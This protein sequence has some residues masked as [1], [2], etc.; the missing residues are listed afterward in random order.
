MSD[1]T[2]APPRPIVG[3]DNTQAGDVHMGSVGGRDIITNTTTGADPIAM[4]DSMFA[5]I[6]EYIWNRDQSQ[7]R[8]MGR[9]ADALEL[10]EI[11]E[12]QRRTADDKDRQQRQRLTDL[13]FKLLT[14]AIL[15]LAL[16]VLLIQVN[17]MYR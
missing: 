3:L 4:A 9:L 7:E 11:S 13:R 2:P 5:F 15:I 10:H 16:A 12:R 1:E 14:T 17:D 6:R 8:D